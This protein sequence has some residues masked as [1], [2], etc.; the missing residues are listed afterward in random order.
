MRGDE[1]KEGRLPL[2]PAQP[3]PPAHHPQAAPGR[4]GEDGHSDHDMIVFA[5][6]SDINFKVSGKRK[7]LSAVPFLIQEYLILVKGFSVKV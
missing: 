4:I 2:R 7:L 1:H 6:K 5:P 3:L